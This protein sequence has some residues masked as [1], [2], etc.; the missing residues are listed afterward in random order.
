MPNHVYNRLSFPELSDK[1]KQI[2]EVIASTQNGLC[3]YYRPMPDDIRNTTSPTQVV[4]QRDYNRI[5]K[6]NAKIDRSKEW[7]HEPKP[8]TQ[9]MQVELKRKYGVDNWYDWA[10]NNW[11]TKWGC[12]DHELDGNTIRFSTAWSV[13]DVSILDALA[14]DFPNFSLHF[15]EEQGWGGYMEYIDG[16]ASSFDEYEAPEWNHTDIDTEHGTITKLLTDIP[17]SDYREGAEVGYYYDFDVNKPVPHDVLKKHKLV[18]SKT[19]ELNAKR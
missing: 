15:E 4:S 1:Q 16:E 12:Y 5:M 10:Y 7:Y 11:G 14:V 19:Q 3:G 18:S 9:K 2:L 8:I 13:F 17:D 6:E